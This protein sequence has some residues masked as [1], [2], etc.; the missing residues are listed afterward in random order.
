M[1]ARMHRAVVTL[2]T[3]VT[4]VLCAGFGVI[5]ALIQ[6]LFRALTSG[7]MPTGALTPNGSTFLPFFFLLPCVMI[8]F[9][10]L[11]VTILASLARSH[12]LITLTNRRLI[13]NQGVLSRTTAEL[14]LKQIETVAIRL[15]W[16]GRI[17]GW[18][19]VVVRGTGGGLFALQF[20]E[21]PEQLYSDLQKIVQSAK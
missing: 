3:I 14:L 20:L 1:Q 4:L 2:P 8:L 7:L 12:T 16:L 19:T 11:V 21:N 10:G 15:P 5:S 9:I 18:G 17:F 6:S 13:I